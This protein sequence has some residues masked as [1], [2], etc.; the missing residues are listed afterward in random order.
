[1]LDAA[2]AACISY[3]AIIDDGRVPHD[4][5][6]HIGVVNDGPIHAHHSSVVRE[7]VSAPLAAGKADAHVTE[8]IVDTAVIADVLAPVAVMEE[9]MSAFKAPVG[10]RPEVARLGSRHPGAG[11]PVITVLAVR[12]VAGGPE[13]AVFGAGWLFVNGEHGRGDANADHDSGKR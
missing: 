5:L 10:G 11:N 9:V 1:M 7:A 12:P 2:R 13:V 6:V 4:C 3:A 8:A